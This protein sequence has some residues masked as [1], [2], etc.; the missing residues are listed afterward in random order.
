MTVC[1]YKKK[2]QKIKKIIRRNIF[3]L[4][5]R[6]RCV[7]VCLMNNIVIINQSNEILYIVYFNK[8]NIGAMD[9]RTA[10]F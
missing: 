1:N 8:L 2:N 9:R 3:A 4:K 5:H 7:F 6:F 10:L